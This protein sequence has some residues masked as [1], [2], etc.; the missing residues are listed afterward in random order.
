M[1]TFKMKILNAQIA[2]YTPGADPDVGF[3]RGDLYCLFHVRS[4]L[5]L[6]CMLPTG[7]LLATHNTKRIQ[8]QTQARA[9]RHER[10]QTPANRCRISS[11]ERS[12]VL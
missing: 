9:H 3:G 7:S 12:G 5:T 11:T 10:R 6:Y 8:T 4:I 2:S 1:I